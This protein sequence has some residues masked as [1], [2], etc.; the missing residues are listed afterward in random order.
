ATVPGGTSLVVTSP[1]LRPDTPLLAGAVAA[2]IEVV[3]DVEL[4]WRLRPAIPGGGRQQWLAVTGTNGKTTTV[5]M[6]ACMLTA[7]GYRAMAV[8][9]VGMS[10]VDAVTAAD[11]CPVLAVELS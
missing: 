9:N 8:G 6:L 7:A 11:P 4:A 5:L 2:G 1:G 3:G 10:V